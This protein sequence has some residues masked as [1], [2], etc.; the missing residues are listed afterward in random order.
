MDGFEEFMSFGQEDTFIG[1][2]D[3]SIFE[4]LVIEPKPGFS[5]N[6]ATSIPTAAHMAVCL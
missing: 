4:I 5:S 3:R 6:A 2:L 1:L